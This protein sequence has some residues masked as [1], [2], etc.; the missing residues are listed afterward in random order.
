MLNKKLTVFFICPYPL[1]QAASQRFRFEQYFSTLKEKGIEF[2]TFP[3]WSL[4]PWSILYKD[5]FGLKKAIFLLVGF[6]KRFFL[7]FSLFRSEYIFIHREATPIGPPWFEWIVARILRKKMIYDFD[8]AIWLPNTSSENTI[9]SRL[10]WHKKVAKICKWSHSVSCGNQYLC[11]FAKQYNKQVYLNPT[12]IDTENIHNPSLYSPKMKSDNVTIGWTGTHSTLK[13][14]EPIIPVIKSLEKKFQGLRFVVIADKNPRYDFSSFCY[15]PWNKQSEIQDL[16]QFDIGLMPLRA[17][18]WANG[19][20]GFKALQ[21][22]AIQVPSIA[23]PVGVNTSIIENGKDGFLCY[24]EDEW[25]NTLSMLIEDN[26]LRKNIGEN[27]RNKIINHYSVT[28]N[29]NNFLSL[30]N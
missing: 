2:E 29:A 16:L 25:Y 15:V 21:Y 17:D 3:F 26:N 5:G 27:G 11:D 1:G 18:L 19:K 8:D 14:L 12:T 10:K 9:A 22:M 7:L 4:S 28:S 23:S 6:F 20:C 13:Y 30:F 24:S